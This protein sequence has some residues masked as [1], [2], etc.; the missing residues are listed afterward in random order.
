[1]DKEEFN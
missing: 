1:S